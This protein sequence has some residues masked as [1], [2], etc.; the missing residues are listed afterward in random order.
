[1]MKPFKKE[2]SETE[3]LFGKLKKGGAVLI[4][5]DSKIEKI[6]FKFVSNYKSRRVN[7]F[8]FS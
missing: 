8:E 3:I 6:N 7:Q 2:E 5:F 4:E 1:M